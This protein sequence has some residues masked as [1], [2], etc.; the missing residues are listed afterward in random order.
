MGNQRLSSVSSKQWLKTADG[1]VFIPSIDNVWYSKL[2]NMGV[3]FLAVTDNHNKDFCVA[4]Y[5]T[6]NE[7]ATACKKLADSYGFKLGGMTF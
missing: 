5:K 4:M 1:D 2:F 6:K 7:A 3:Y